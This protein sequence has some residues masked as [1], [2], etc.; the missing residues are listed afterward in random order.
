MCAHVV[1]VYLF[2]SEV[3]IEITEADYQQREGQGGNIINARVS[4]NRDLIND[5]VIN[6]YPVTYDRYLNVLGLTL[7]D[8][9]PRRE[10][11]PV[12]EA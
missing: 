12:F 7:P 1:C 10:T 3:R 9:F 6:F 2:S 4:Y 5:I 8:D 11:G